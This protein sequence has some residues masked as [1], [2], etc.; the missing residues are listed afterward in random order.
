MMKTVNVDNNCV[1]LDEAKLLC[2]KMKLFEN[3]KETVWA[4][5]KWIMNIKKDN[6]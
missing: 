3:G 5:F 2:K 1:K 4:S 6:K